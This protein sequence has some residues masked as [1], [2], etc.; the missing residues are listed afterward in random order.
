[1]NPNTYWQW[2]IDGLGGVVS[3]T[4]QLAEEQVPNTAA[5][6]AKLTL[7]VE[8]LM[9]AVDRQEGKQSDG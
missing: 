4:A 9:K 5:Q 7:L 1:M 3:M 6:Q 8:R 2:V